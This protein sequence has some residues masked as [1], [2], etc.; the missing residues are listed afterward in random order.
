[1]IFLFICLINKTKENEKIFL[2]AMITVME[3][4][5]SCAQETTSKNQ[6]AKMAK[7]GA[8][9]AFVSETIDYY[10]Q[11]RWTTRFVLLTM[12]PSR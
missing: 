6:T 5:T 1:M 11:R 10:T 3:L 9:M 4:A 2:L 8:G 12:V 7:S